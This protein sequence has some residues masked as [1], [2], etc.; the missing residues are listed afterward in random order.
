MR[1]VP[2]TRCDG[3][4]DALTAFAAA[5]PAFDMGA[6]LDVV[7]WPRTHDLQPDLP[8]F[9]QGLTHP[10]LVEVT[11]PEVLCHEL[12]HLHLWRAVGDPDHAHRATGIFGAIGTGSAEGRCREALSR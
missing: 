4:A 12:G 7:V 3:V 11:G 2:R 9:T 6:P 1:C 5:L 10:D 8:G